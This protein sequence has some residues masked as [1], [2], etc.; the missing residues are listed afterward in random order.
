MLAAVFPLF[1]QDVLRGE[2]RVD[3]EP[4]YAA[5]LDAPYPLDTKTAQTRALEEAAMFFSAMIYGWSFNYDIGEKARGIAE[6]FELTPLGTIP[7]G[8]AGLMVT[9]AGIRNMRLYMWAD[10]RL[11]A[12]QKRRIGMWRA[13]TVQNAQAVGYG[14]LGRPAGAADWLS[15][16]RDALEDAARAAVRAVL[17]GGE[18]NRPKEARGF[19]ALAAFPSYWMDAGQ[20]AASARFRVQITEITPFAAY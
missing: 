15:I 13:G 16:K 11:T 5:F 2:V 10:Y 4:V 9:G 20:W 8:D 3:L 17:R 6:E 19:I 18:R 14:P 12:A 7:F 1:P